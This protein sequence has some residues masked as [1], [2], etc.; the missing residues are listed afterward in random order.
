MIHFNEGKLVLI[1]MV[2]SF[3]SFSTEVFSGVTI[4]LGPP[5]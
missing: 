5:G 3:P 2:T 1:A 4:N